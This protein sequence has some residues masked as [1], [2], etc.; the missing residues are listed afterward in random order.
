MLQLVTLFLQ[1]ENC[2]VAQ[3]YCSIALPFG[4]VS[5]DAMG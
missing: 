5:A 1:K 4:W 2:V 3:D